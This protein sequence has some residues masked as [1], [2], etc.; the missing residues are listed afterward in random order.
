MALRRSANCC[1]T[2]KGKESFLSLCA[3]HISFGLFY[4]QAVRFTSGRL[5]KL[6]MKKLIDARN[7]PASLSNFPFNTMKD[8]E[9][10]A[11][12]TVCPIYLLL[13]DAFEEIQ[14]TQS[15]HPKHSLQIKLDHLSSH[16]GRAQG[17]ANVLRGMAHNASSRRC[18]VP[19]ELLIKH[20]ASHEDFLRHQSQKQA[21]RDVCFDLA[22]FAHQHLTT[23]SS[24]MK[25]DYNVLKPW[26]VLFLPVT[27]IRA[28]LDRLQE[29][30]FDVFS[31]KLHTRTQN[32]PLKL[33]WTSM[34]L[35][36]TSL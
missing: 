2:S 6:H 23:A 27:P 14:K 5:S 28:Y 31:P 21:V 20:K 26:L 16:I 11:D 25:T 35:K 33:W 15:D 29:Q 7:S 30:D 24:L 1:G 36:Y 3:N 22:T 32:L 9:E 34:K 12:A 18:Y 10:Y 4:M 8:L 13:N 19:T 17:I